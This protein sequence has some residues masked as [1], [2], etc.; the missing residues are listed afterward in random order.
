MAQ[1]IAIEKLTLHALEQNSNLARTKNADFFSEWQDSLPELTSFEMA[2]LEHIRVIYENF[3]SRSALENTVSL[4]IVSPLLDTAGLFVPPFYVETEKSVEVVSQDGS[5]TIRGRLDIAI[6]KDLIWVLTIE[7]SVESR[8]TGFSLIVGLPQVLSYM[9]AAPT[10]QQQLYGMVTNGRN[11][12]FV[13]LDRTSR[14]QPLYAMSEEFVFSRGDD[15][16]QTLRILKRLADV[17][18]TA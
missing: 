17:A 10:P 18:A 5:V 6:I 11:F 15:L 13:K 12:I 3:E 1:A 16:E 4:T 9:L 14:E 8:G 2:R 7:S